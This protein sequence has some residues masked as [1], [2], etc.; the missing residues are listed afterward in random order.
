VR[1]SPSNQISSHPFSF[2]TLPDLFFARNP[3]PFN[4]LPV[5]PH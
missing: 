3:R 5:L 2:T 4:N 1:N